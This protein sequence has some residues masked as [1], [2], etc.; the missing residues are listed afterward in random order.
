MSLATPPP[1]ARS[2]VGA[3]PRAPDLV[4]LLDRLL[5]AARADSPDHDFLDQAAG[6]LELAG[7]HL[8]RRGRLFL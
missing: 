5:R 6:Q 8:E 7:Q 4:L 2:A 3:A 1:A